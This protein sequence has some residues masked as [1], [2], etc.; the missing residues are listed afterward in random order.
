MKLDET[1]KPGNVWRQPEVL[2]TLLTLIVVALVCVAFQYA[3]LHKK[4]AVNNKAAELIAKVN[5]VPVQHTV[6]VQGN[7]KSL[8]AHE[9]ASEDSSIEPP[10][11]KDD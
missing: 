3:N 1:G 11:G 5:P 4:I 6:Y 9:I 2:F 10:Q 7:P 8:V